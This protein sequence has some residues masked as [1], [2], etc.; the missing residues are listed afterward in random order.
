MSNDQLTENKTTNYSDGSELVPAEVAARQER[1]GGEPPNTPKPKEQQS[2]NA[3]VNMTGGYTV[4]GQG[5]VNNYAVTPKIYRADYPTP[6]QQKKYA[7][8]GI[9]AL[10]LV[11]G[12]IVVA[13][14]V[15]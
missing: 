3:D 13:I 11:S 15:S 7:I 12:I 2:T 6:E 9:L 8:Q 14:A 1:E 5:L 10:L 4:S